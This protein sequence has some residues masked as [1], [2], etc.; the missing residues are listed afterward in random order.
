MKSRIPF[1]AEPGK[2]L[3]SGPIF[4][5]RYGDWCAACYF[6]LLGFFFWP[7]YLGPFV[8][9]LPASCTAQSRLAVREGLRLQGKRSWLAGCAPPHLRGVYSSFLL[10][11]RGNGRGGEADGPCMS[12]SS[13]S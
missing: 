11:R 5:S 4:R 8:L 6:L 9:V 1:H 2:K 12:V 3:F 7:V 10:Y 13:S